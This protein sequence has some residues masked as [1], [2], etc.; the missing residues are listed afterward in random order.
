MKMLQNPQM[1]EQMKVMMQDPAVKERLKRLL[2][3]LGP[4]SSI[5]GGEAVAAG[6]DDA[7][8][9]IWERMQAALSDPAMLEKLS[10]AASSEKFQSRMQQLAS[11]PTFAQAASSY[12]DEMKQEVCAWCG[13]LRARTRAARLTRFSSERG[14]SSGVAAGGMRRFFS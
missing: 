2:Q 4:D 7:L 3:R 9:Q 12:V 1:M 14:R 11:D 5:N 13:T 6:N 10:A 8:D